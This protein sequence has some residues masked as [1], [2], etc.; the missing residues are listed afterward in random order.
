MRLGQTRAQG[1]QTVGP[2]LGTS[3][4]VERYNRTPENL[5]LSGHQELTSP[6]HLLC[7]GAGALWNSR[8]ILDTTLAGG[9][10]K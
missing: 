3:R 6:E 5:C 2:A 1:E 4:L 7:A 8:V 10:N 9:A